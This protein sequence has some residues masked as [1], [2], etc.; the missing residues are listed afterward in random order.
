MQQFE[1]NLWQKHQ[2]SHD[3]KRNQ[4]FRAE[5][6][7]GV[8]DVGGSAV[9]CATLISVEFVFESLQMTARFP[10]LKNLLGKTLR[11]MDTIANMLVQIKN[12]N[13][14][15][16]TSVVVP[17]SN[18]KY[19]IATLLEREKYVGSVVKKGKKIKKFI[20]ID[21]VYD[22]NAPRIHGIRRLS[23]LSRRHYVTVADIAKQRRVHGM[24]VVS[25]P[26]GV[27]TGNEAYKEKTGGEAL[28]RVW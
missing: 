28:L 13:N 8:F 22:G 20:E 7:S 26:K 12:G 27:L 24:L 23:K 6:Y 4:N 25:T 2:L 11:T 15:G 16:K 9:I 1:L 21:L 3:R 18:I 5:E 10:V 19:A 17:F 14:A